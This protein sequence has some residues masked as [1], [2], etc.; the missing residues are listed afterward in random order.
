MAYWNVH[1]MAMPWQL[2]E[3][4]RRRPKG[5]PRR[6]IVEQLPSINVKTLSIP[7]PYDYKTYILPNIS[8]RLPQLASA[9]VSFQTV[10]FHFPSLHRGQIG[11]I[12]TFNLKHIRVGFGIRHTFICGCGRPVLKLY[13]HSQRLACRRCIGAINASQALNQNQRP[14]LQAIRIADF[15]DGHPR[16]F[17]RTRERLRLKL[18][19]K[20]MRAQGR[21]GTKARSHWE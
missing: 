11:P 20:L 5:R 15:L 9:K 8:F 6:L 13:Y 21:L 7:S 4:L 10:E 16:L 17:R 14:I 3:G 12:Q 2:A 1:T 19:E 18:G